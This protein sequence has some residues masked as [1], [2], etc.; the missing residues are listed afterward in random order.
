MRPPLICGTSLSV[1]EAAQLM[2]AEGAGCVLV[3]GRDGLGIVTDRDLRTRVVATGAAL[4]GCLYVF[5][6][7]GDRT[8]VLGLTPD[9]YGYNPRADR[10]TRLP[11]LPI[12]I[13]GLTGAAAV[14]DRIF[15]PGGG[16]TLGGDA[17]TNVLQIFRPNMR[18]G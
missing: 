16:L 2:E 5:G 14:G 10:W 3:E 7:E 18:C 4:G 12:A 8:H 1:R 9:V 17:P 6:G 11:N 15:I 13:H